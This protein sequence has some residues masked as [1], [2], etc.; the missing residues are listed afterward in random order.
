[1]KSKVI[2]TLLTITLIASGILGFI[3]FNIRRVEA[4]AA[5]LLVGGPATG[6]WSGH[7]GNRTATVGSTVRYTVNITGVTGLWTFDFGLT[8]GSTILALTA[9]TVRI[10]KTTYA[11]GLLNSPAVQ[12]FE[13]SLDEA[14]KTCLYRL[15]WTESAG[16]TPFTG[17][18]CAV[19]LDFRVLSPGGECYVYFTDSK[20]S[21]NNGNPIAHTR[22]DGYF[23][24]T[25]HNRVPIASYTTS[26]ATKIANKT[27]VLFDA[28][29]SSDPDG[30][31]LTTYI[32]TFGQNKPK[33]PAIESAHPYAPN[34]N[35]QWPLTHSGAIL[36]RVF[37]PNITTES[38]KDYV[39]VKD[40]NGLLLNSWSGLYGDF[41][42]QWSK[43]GRG[44]TLYINFTSDGANQFWG[45]KATHYQ[46]KY[47]VVTSTTSYTYTILQSDYRTTPYGPYPFTTS[48][49]VVDSEHSQSN[50]VSSA[51]Q[52]VHPR[53]VAKFTMSPNVTHYYPKV[54]WAYIF[55]PRTVSFDASGSYDPDP[56]GGILWYSWDFGDG[57]KDNKSTPGTSHTFKLKGGEMVVALVVK[58]TSDGLMSYFSYK[59]YAYNMTE[60]A[61]AY[62]SWNIYPIEPPPN[63]N[64][65]YDISQ[66]NYING[67]DLY[68]MGRSYY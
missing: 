65:F 40:K 64:L 13:T 27:S 34:T 35:V 21:D 23:Y 46:F 5:T 10:P 7:R 36:M 51:F 4:Q 28:T 26:P 32:W 15:S 2:A 66:D 37:F 30:T 12:I 16:A 24:M 14:N 67:T 3:G 33:I 8:W 11:D 60:F 47:Q 9:R 19:Y 49:S 55:C 39:R 44:D 50:T 41:P 31:A 53:P 61:V 59:I 38:G 6:T 1:M 22:T 20:L 63:W 56:G 29:G 25:L 17:S 42:E 68:I 18:G 54:N 52:V 57:A 43:W 58:D 62:G 45:F 48:L